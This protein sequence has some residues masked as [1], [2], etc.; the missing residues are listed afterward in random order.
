MPTSCLL[1]ARTQ[2]S[3]IVPQFMAVYIHRGSVYIL[4]LYV[5][6]VCIGF[7][8]I[9]CMFLCVSCECWLYVLIGRLACVCW[10]TCL[11]YVCLSWLSVLVACM[12]WFYFYGNCIVLY[13]I[14][15]EQMCSKIKQ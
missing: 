8:L 4:C 3:R 15:L 9:D 13:S 2:A 10:F 1:L 12:C 5:S 11:L 7:F 14:S 6:S